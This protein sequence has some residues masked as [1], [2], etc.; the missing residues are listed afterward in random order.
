MRAK[1]AMKLHPLM[2]RFD[3]NMIS[4][5]GFEFSD[6]IDLLITG[7]NSA[8]DR[9]N[10]NVRQNSGLEHA[11]VEDTDELQDPLYEIFDADTVLMLNIVK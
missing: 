7:S 2:K 5:N 11:M 10:T 6:N 9:R 8:R 3:S 1:A 4:P